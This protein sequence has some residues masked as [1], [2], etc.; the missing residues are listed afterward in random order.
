MMEEYWINC[1]SPVIEEEYDNA[2][3]VV[4]NNCGGTTIQ[5]YLRLTPVTS[6]YLQI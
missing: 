2:P 5:G 4:D 3:T 6:V 1:S